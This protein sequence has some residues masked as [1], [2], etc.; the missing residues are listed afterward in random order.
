MQPIPE[1]TAPVSFER[2]GRAGAI[3]EAVRKAK[4]TKR[5]TSQGKAGPISPVHEVQYNERS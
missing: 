4:L 2:Q 5:V 3:V 1:G